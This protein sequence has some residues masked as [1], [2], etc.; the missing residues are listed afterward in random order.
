MPIAEKAPPKEERNSSFDYMTRKAVELTA[1]YARACSQRRRENAAPKSPEPRGR[2]L[3]APPGE[4]EWRHPAHL[5]MCRSD[6][7]G[8][9]WLH[10]FHRICYYLLSVE[11]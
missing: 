8:H 6:L 1:V 10:R 7:G 4:K 3:S 2:R 5:H 9:K 11:I